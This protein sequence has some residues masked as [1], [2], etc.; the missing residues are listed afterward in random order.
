[1]LTKKHFKEVAK[2]IADPDMKLGK[3]KTKRLAN[4]FC[5]Y[6]KTV[7]PHFKREA[8]LKACGLED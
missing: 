8:F 3:A 5:R 4:E 7:N 2:I 1:M 6:F